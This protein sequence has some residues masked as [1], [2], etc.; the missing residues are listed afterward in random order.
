MLLLQGLDD[1]VVPPNQSAA[2][3]AAVRAKGLPLAHI[4]FEGEGHGFRGETAQR[5]S[6]E[7]ELSF[8]SQI[9]DF[10]LA[11]HFDPIP[12]ENFPAVFVP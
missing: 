1:K 8:Y 12:I 9:L 5:R 7:A 10:P 2:M 11:D 4:E 6:L 3:A